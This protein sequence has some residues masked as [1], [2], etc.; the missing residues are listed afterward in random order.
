[1]DSI[2][3]TYWPGNKLQAEVY[4]KMGQPAIGLKEFDKNGT[5]VKHP[6]IAVKEV[7]QLSLFNKIELK[8]TLS[9]KTSEVEFYKGELKDGKYLYSK[10]P[11][12]FSR[13]GVASLYYTVPKGRAIRERINIISRSR[14]EYGNTLVLQRVYNLSASN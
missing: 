14:T 13:D 9:D 6:T 12:I 2:V 1:M 7:D 8:I 4:F 10:T 3:K 5:P 11:V